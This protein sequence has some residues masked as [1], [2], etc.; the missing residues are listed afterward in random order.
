MAR[1]LVGFSIDAANGI[2]ADSVASRRTKRNQI[3]ILNRLFILEIIA[4]LA[5][6][7]IDP[8]RV[9]NRRLSA[10][11]AATASKVLRA[12]TLVTIDS[13]EAALKWCRMFV[14]AVANLKV[15]LR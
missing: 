7:A 1:V 11:S 8:N 14:A 15:V 2:R 5:L 10:F 4:H 6:T 3:I 9:A 12:R 13:S